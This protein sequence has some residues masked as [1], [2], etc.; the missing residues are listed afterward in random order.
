MQTASLAAYPMD[1]VRRRLMMQ[2]GS[3]RSQWLYSGTVDCWG[4]VARKEGVRAF[5]K[6]ALPN[7][8]R[9]TGGALVLTFY[10]FMHQHFHWTGTAS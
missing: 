1:T 8:F 5:Y 4:T 6:G 7:M 2:S 10:E 9:T 3:A